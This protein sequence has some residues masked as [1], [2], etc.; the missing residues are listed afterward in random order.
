MQRNQDSRN[1]I[2]FFCFSFLF[3][4]VALVGLLLRFFLP[5][6]LHIFCILFLPSVLAVF[7][8]T[9]VLVQG[10][11]CVVPRLEGQDSAIR[12]LFDLGFCSI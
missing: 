6:F 5:V 11:F 12:P 3:F 7:C 2:N 4:L 8:A 10:V 9:A 1:T